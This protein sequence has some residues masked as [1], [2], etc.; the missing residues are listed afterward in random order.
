MA[1]NV[2][3]ACRRPKHTAYEVPSPNHL[4]YFFISN[5]C[6]C[7]SLATIFWHTWATV[8]MG[9]CLKCDREPRTRTNIYM[10]IIFG[11]V[12]AFFLLSVV[13]VKWNQNLWKFFSYVQLQKH[14]FAVLVVPFLSLLFY[15]FSLFKSVYLTRFGFFFVFLFIH[16][17]IICFFIKW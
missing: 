11:F 17:R 15:L 7:R 3:V 4:F 8:C 13:T 6:R 10:H 16:S 1:S 5:G 12:S 9:Y 2:H 14:L